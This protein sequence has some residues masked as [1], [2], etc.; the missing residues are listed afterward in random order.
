M[1]GTI[2]KK[3]IP[4]KNYRFFFFQ[5]N[6]VNAQELESEYASLTVL[7]QSDFCIT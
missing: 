2:L 6:L 5:Q 4:S 7:H 1:R 3:N